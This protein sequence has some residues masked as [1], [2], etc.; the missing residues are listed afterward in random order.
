[1]DDHALSLPRATRWLTAALAAATALT[2]C[3]Q[4]PHGSATAP[5]ATAPTAGQLHLA[6]ARTTGFG[7][8]KWGDAEADA[9]AKDSYGKNAAQQ[10]PGSLYTV[11][12]ADGSRQ[13]WPK[14]DLLKQ[15]M[16]GLGI[17]VAVLDSGVNNQ[18]P[19]LNY[20]GKVTYGPDLSIEGNGVLADQDTFGH[21]T[22]MA[23]I[24]AGR[25]ASNPSSQLPTAPADVQLGVAPDAKLL[26]LKLATTDGSTDVTEVIAALDWVVEHPVMPN[27]TRVRVINLSYGTY[28]SNPYTVDPLAAAAENAWK[29]GIVVVA[30]AGNDG[31]AP[32]TL[33]D[34][35]YDP[36]V[37]AVGAT[38]SNDRADGYHPDKATVASFS[39]IG[40]STRHV[41]LVAP[42]TSIVSARD[43]GSY[44][45]TNYPSGLVSGDSSKRLFRGSGTSQAT[46]VV[47]GS[48]ALLLQAFPTLTP[49]QV[50]A[51]LTSSADHLTN[52]AAV[53][54]GAGQLDLT[55]A[56]A[57]AQKLTAATTTGA[58]ARAAAAQK[59]PSSTGLG[60]IDAARGNSVLV[61]VDGNPITGEVDAQ[62]N[63][64]HAAAW[65]QASRNLTAW[66]GGQWMGVTWTGSGWDLS[67]G[68]S[69][70]RWASA[71][72]ASARW[73][74]ADWSSARWSSA[75]WASARWASA[76]WASARWSS[77]TW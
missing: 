76:R 34:P 6:A 73:A 68:L 1:M 21:G 5:R 77:S 56:F 19:A 54:Q 33:T 70:A 64:W 4:G 42:G 46:A 20:A 53:Q 49:D 13:Q 58:A 7:D 52:V 22:F 11:E 57:A 18:V 55:K 8:A 27:G 28:S 32:G 35:A 65:V 51:V 12:N 62:G 23:G 61:D 59:F 16:T 69:S 17:G 36:Y 2:L 38:S 10:D 25:A 31:S 67:S 29:H 71:R 48:V 37:L 44:V 14:K 39:N 15:Q 47:S 45:D 50:K 75:R 43:P 74:D 63:P 40:T 60:S 3:A 30:S 24:I 26:A 41:D 72:W 9:N 66:N